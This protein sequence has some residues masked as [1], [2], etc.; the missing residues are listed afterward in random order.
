MKSIKKSKQKLQNINRFTNNIQCNYTIDKISVIQFF[1]IKHYIKTK[2]KILKEIKQVQ[3]FVKGCK[4]LYEYDT[5][6][7]INNPRINCKKYC[8][9]EA[10]AKYN[11]DLKLYKCGVLT[12]KPILPALQKLNELLQNT[13]L[14]NII[15]F[16]RINQK[17]KSG[18][19]PQKNLEFNM[20][21]EQK[22][23]SSVAVNSHISINDIKAKKFR[24]SLKFNSKNKRIVNNNHDIASIS[25]G[26]KRAALDFGGK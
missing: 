9:L 4:L 13:E 21:F 2:K 5:R 7:W 25:I 1:K 18:K 14:S 17:F 22:N 8:K 24:N 11:R 16:K 10:K 23:A 15:F 6:R 12:K 3:R 26:K 20:G 19:L